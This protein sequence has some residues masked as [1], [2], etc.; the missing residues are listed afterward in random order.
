MPLLV[1][2]LTAQSLNCSHLWSGGNKTRFMGSHNDQTR[3]SVFPSHTGQGLVPDFSTQLHLLLLQIVVGFQ[4]VWGGLLRLSP[5]SWEPQSL[6]LVDQCF[7]CMY[8]HVPCVRLVP[9]VIRRVLQVLWNWSY[10]RL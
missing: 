2:S 5:D 6:L 4:W 10:K 3:F 7:A 9:V 1:S 8:V